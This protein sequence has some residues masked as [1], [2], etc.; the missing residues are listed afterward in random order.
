MLTRGWTS[1][2][3]AIYRIPDG[4]W[5]GSRELSSEISFGFTFSGYNNFMNQRVGERVEGESQTSC[6]CHRKQDFV[7]QL[8]K[9]MSP[10]KWK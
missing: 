10:N 3:K 1:P 2:V 7:S 8:V 6:R 5:S 9:I 4:A